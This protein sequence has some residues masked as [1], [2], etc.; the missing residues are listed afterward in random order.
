MSFFNYI[1]SP[2]LYKVYRDGSIQSLYEPG[3]FEKWGDQVISTL[4][5]MW[6]ISYYTSPLIITFLYRRGYFVAESISSFAKVST[7]IGLLVVISL[8]V[9]SFG[10]SSSASYR[11]FVKALEQAKSSVTSTNLKDKLRL[12][13]FEFKEWP[14]DF[15]VKDVNGDQS[16]RHVALSASRSKPFWISTLPCEIV[17]YIAIHTFGIRMIYPGSIRLLQSFLHPILVQGRAKLVEEES[18]K[19]NKLRTIDG[20]DIDTIFIDRRSSVSEKNSNGRTLVVCSEGNAGFYEIGI[21][22]T[23]LAMKYS[24]L[25]WNHPGFGGST[26]LPYPQQDQNAMDAVMQFA[27]H[28]LGFQT[29]DIILFGWSIGGYSSL[30]AAAQYPDIKGVILDAT[31]DDVL[32]LAIPRMPSS[33]SGIV[34]IAIRDYA[35]LNNIDL[36]NQYNGPVLMI[37]RTED[38]I[39]AEDNEIETNRGNGLLIHL[40]KIRFPKIFQTEQIERIT[41]MLS[42]PLDKTK[43]LTGGHELMHS[44]LLSYVSENSKQYPLDIG[45]EYTSEQRNQMAEYLV[46]KHLID[47]KSTHCTPLPTEHFRIPWDVPSIENDF[48]FT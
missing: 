26:G 11:N 37:R 12:Y 7:G 34:R 20:N 3:G 24:V 23:P 1:L 38:E 2:R 29:E 18:G 17:A 45:E 40:L 39:I 31:F 28:K 43:D 36:I 32:Q 8:C 27:I 15:D 9:R 4:S 16:K 41:K 46:R 42:Q 19:R 13:D 22:T 14:V 35:N 6:N 10:R 25:G 30:V 21:M 33:I 5:L 44:L 48:I 47:F